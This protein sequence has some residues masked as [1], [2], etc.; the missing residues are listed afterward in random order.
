MVSAADITSLCQAIVADVRPRKIILFG[1][2]AWGNPSADSDLD[3][4]VVARGSGRTAE[5]AAA[6][7]T[8]LRTAFPVDLLLR[9]P[10]TVRRRLAIGDPFITRIVREGKTL[11]ESAR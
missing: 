2:Y 5:R 6:I 11:Y 10:A 1:S 4:L 7:R 3:L 9:S 8:K